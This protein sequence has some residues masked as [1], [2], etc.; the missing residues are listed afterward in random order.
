LAAS[1]LIAAGLYFGRKN[2]L[3]P[4]RVFQVAAT[5]SA[6]PTNA[7]PAE[8]V[9]LPGA[10]ALPHFERGEVIRMEIPFPEGPVQADVLV[11]Q[12]GIARAVR[13]VQ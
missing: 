4:A 12:D 9:V 13:F 3:P 10:T 11:G 2:D 1:L 7:A 5:P 8:F 6:P